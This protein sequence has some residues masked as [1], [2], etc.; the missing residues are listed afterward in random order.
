MTYQQVLIRFFLAVVMGGII[1]YEREYQKRPAGFIT[2]ILVCI[3]AA[4]TSMIQLYLV[5]DSIDIIGEYPQLTNALKVDS[6]RIISQVVSGIGFLGAGTIIHNKGSIKGLTTAATLW[7][8]ACI[9][10]AVGMGY[11]FLSI[12]A[13]IGVYCVLVLLKKVKFRIQDKN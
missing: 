11:Y 1:G 9:G 3:G 8:V 10:I 13:T 4:I 2:N 7:V 12:V 6:G 5:Q